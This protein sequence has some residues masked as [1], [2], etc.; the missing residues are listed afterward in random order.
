MPSDGLVEE[1][2]CH[3]YSLWHCYGGK[4]QQGGL[5]M[6]LHWPHKLWTDRIQLDPSKQ[7]LEQWL[8]SKPFGKRLVSVTSK[9]PKESD[10]ISALTIMT[11]QLRSSD[12]VAYQPVLQEV[13]K[14]TETLDDW[15]SLCA[16]AFGYAIDKAP[17]ERAFMDDRS[18]FYFIQ[19]E[20]KNI[21]TVLTWR[22]G[23]DLGIHQ[24]GI[25]PEGRGHQLATKALNQIESLARESKM[26]S[27][28]LQ[29]SRKGRAI[30]KN[31]GFV[32]IGFL[33]SYL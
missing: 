33:V 21:G 26:T 3:L 14:H 6:H 23:N 28:S 5:N 16:K 11:K 18:K 12:V 29:A 7:E 24:M 4:Q 15:L 30:Y 9:R 27:M 10:G 2:I 19:L 32:P 31:H 17:V 22:V 13:N 8:K 1:N 20:G 25:V